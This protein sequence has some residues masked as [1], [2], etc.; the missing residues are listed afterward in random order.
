MEVFLACLLKHCLPV[1][2][3]DFASDL[4]LG[5]FA[6]IRRKGTGRSRIDDAGQ[7]FQAREQWAEEAGDL[8]R[9]FVAIR[10]K[11]ENCLEDVIGAEAERHLTERDEAA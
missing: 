11:R 5:W 9:R 8:L 1:L 7:S 2:G 4:Q 10:G 6:A 3:V